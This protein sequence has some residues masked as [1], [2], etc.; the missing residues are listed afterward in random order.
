M[1]DW[2][3]HPPAYKNRNALVRGTVDP[4]TPAFATR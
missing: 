4:A 2:F 1:P 3:R